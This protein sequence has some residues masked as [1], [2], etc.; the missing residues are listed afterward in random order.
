MAC[1]I[2]DFIKTSKSQSATSIRT[3]TKYPLYLIVVLDF[4]LSVATTHKFYQENIL[5][6]KKTL[7]YSLIA[8]INKPNPYHFTAFVKDPNVKGLKHFAESA[9]W[10]QH[11]GVKTSNFTKISDTIEKSLVSQ[12]AY[13]L[14]YQ[15]QYIL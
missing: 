3:I 9:G 13:I 14:I 7:K 15:Q 5:L 10:F 4:Q 8:T 11:D 6:E 1:P 2:C 12:R